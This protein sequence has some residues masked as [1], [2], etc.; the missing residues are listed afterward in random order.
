MAID[1]DYVLTPSEDYEFFPEVVELAKALKVI[2]DDTD[3]NVDDINDKTAQTSE[4]VARRLV[5]V[6]YK[7]DLSAADN[8]K[9]YSSLANISDVLEEMTA[10]LQ[11][12]VL[13]AMDDVLEVVANRPEAFIK[14]PPGEAVVA[15]IVFETPKEQ[16]TP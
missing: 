15:E 9:A 2:V 6:A 10:K 16:E 14:Q 7:I 8:I 3:K 12:A 5:R 13:K 11:E 1:L 4:E